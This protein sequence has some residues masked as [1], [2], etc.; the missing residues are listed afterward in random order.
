M[1]TQI[2]MGG[3][4]LLIIGY[5]GINFTGEL[6]KFLIGENILYAILY[7]ILLIELLKNTPYVQPVLLLVASFNAG[8]VSRSI[9]SPRGE[10]GE[11][12]IEHIPLLTLIL[13]V[14]FS[15]LAIVLRGG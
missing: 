11:L 9:I 15:A 14:A 10:I 1:I 6:P 5:I 12:A 4:I 2:E 3:L 13:I 8:R 7:S